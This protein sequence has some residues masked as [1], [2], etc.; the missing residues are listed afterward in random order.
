MRPEAHH[1]QQGC[2]QERHHRFAGEFQR[3]AQGTGRQAK[4]GR[5]GAPVPVVMSGSVLTERDSPVAAALAAHLP[6]LLPEAELRPATLPPVAGA[7]LDALAEGGVDV[8]EP[9]VSGLA[10]TIPAPAFFRT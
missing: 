8:T 6:Q 9:V 4:L 10:A 2:G 1:R 7:A 3:G 5:A